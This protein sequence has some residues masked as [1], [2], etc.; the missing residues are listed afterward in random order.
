MKKL[1]LITLGAALMLGGFI[2]Y[3]SSF[4]ESNPVITFIGSWASFLMGLLCWGELFVTEAIKRD[5]Y[6]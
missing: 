6:V 4:I 3:Y 5:K 2:L 1:T